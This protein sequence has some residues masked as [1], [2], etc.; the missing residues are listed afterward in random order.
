MYLLLYKWTLEEY[1][2]RQLPLAGGLEGERFN[3]APLF[4]IWIF[5]SIPHEYISVHVLH[6]KVDGW[7]VK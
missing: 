4:N 5:F 6:A 2:L 1:K 7:V 3:S